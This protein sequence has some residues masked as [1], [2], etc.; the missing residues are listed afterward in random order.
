MTTTKSNSINIKYTIFRYK[1]D[2]SNIKFVKIYK[3]I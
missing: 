3:I 1:M 2:V